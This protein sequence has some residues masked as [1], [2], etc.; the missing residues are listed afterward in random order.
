MTGSAPSRLAERSTELAVSVVA[1][2]RSIVAVHSSA[3]A[4]RALC[5]LTSNLMGFVQAKP[6]APTRLPFS[7][8]SG[9]DAVAWTPAAIV[10]A[11]I[12][13]QRASVGVEVRQ[14]DRCPRPS[15]DGD[16][17]R[18]AQRYVRVPVGD[19]RGQERAV[20]E[21]QGLSAL[22]QGRQVRIVGA[23]TRRSSQR[24]EVRDFWARR[25]QRQRPKR[26]RGHLDTCQQAP[27]GV[28]TRDGGSDMALRSTRVRAG[29]PRP[30]QS[31]AEGTL[32]SPSRPRLPVTSTRG[33]GQGPSRSATGSEESRD[34]R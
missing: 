3:T 34:R 29:S 27:A 24:D 23:D 31:T 13:G 21:P 10:S 28:E 30:G 8:Y 25:G 16:R 5:S 15:G 18:R 33:P 7:R 11:T 12:S 1:S 22:V 26:P 32:A 19:R 14:Q 20:E 6:I 9:N 17:K 4:C 2:A